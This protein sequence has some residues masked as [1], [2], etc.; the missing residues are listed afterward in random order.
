MKRYTDKELHLLLDDIESN[1]SERKES[2]NDVDKACQAV[3]AFAND[4]V[5]NNQPGVLFIGVKN[6]GAPSNL[7]ITEELL[8]NLVGMKTNGNI[9]PPPT[10]SVEKRVVKE[11]EVAVVTVMP[12]DMP[13]VRYKGRIWVRSGPGRGVATEQD[14]RILIERRRH[15]HIPFDLFPAHGATIHDLSRS[16]F[17]HE[18][19]PMA[20]APDVLEANN[21]TYEEKLASSRM[22]VSPQDTTPTV[23][24]LLSLGRKP[25][26]FVYG[27]RIQFLRIDGLALT[28]E[29]IDHAY[30]DGTLSDALKEAGF[31]LAAHNR[32]AVDV[33]GAATHK[34]DADY[35]LSAVNQILYN[36]VQHRTYEGTN[37]PTRIHWYNDR[38]EII[39]PGG[40]Y[41]NVTAANFGQPGVNDYRNPNISAVMK[42]LG[43]IQSFGR[44]IAIAKMELERN[45][46]PPLVFFVENSVV[47]CTI[48][49]G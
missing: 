40:P 45:G 36:A 31:K 32:Q 46:N 9:L 17:E 44:G 6:N 20:V 34:I 30:I 47:I 39:S 28:D 48:R 14:E 35:P 4:L 42:S 19:L 38:I 11:A 41:G 12:S 16:F 27:A 1:L 37:T 26:E 33:T 8:N 5:N 3:C 2:F 18:Y 7:P 43:F 21:R 23:T 10:L 13:P 29:V 49:K 22:I 24:G 15:K 25:H